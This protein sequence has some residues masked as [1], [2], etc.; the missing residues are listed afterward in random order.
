MAEVRAQLLAG[1][2]EALIPL[3]SQ[4]RRL[5]SY[6][7]ALSYDLDPLISQRAI[8]AFGLAA[9]QLAADDPDFVR[10]HFRRLVWLLNDESGGI[11]WRAAELLGEALFHCHALFPEYLPI[12]I[13]LLDMEP[14]DAPRFQSSV[15]RAISRVAQVDSSAMQAARPLL[16]PLLQNPEPQVADLAG[17][18]LNLL[19]QK[20]S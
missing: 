8:Q 3:V 1:Q 6:L 10:N 20:P 19:D 13:S 2:L 5:L 16:L 18:C 15:L 17:Q 14:E 12:L 7:T 4:H 11:G 9:K